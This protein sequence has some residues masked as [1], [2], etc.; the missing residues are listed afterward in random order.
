MATTTI[1]LTVEDL[2]FIPEERVGDRHELI[3]GELLVTPVPITKH[4]DVSLNLTLELAAFIRRRRLG[5]LYVAPSG[6]RLHPDTLV[7]PDIHFVAKERRAIIGEK[8]T[9]GPPDL[10]IE[11][12]SP[13]TRRRDLH[14]KR[15]LYAS[16]GVQ[17][18]WIVDPDAETVMV[19]SLADGRYER[20]PVTEEGAITSRVLPG[21]ELS[22]EQVFADI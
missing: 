19:L 7:I 15:N 4:Q 8:L 14:A 13:G 9:D 22:Q 5:K 6:V 11:I 1:R 3:D 16:F 2:E 12:L 18:Y 17:E 20:I 21:L 10:V